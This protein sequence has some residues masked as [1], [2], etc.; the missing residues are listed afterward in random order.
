MM[1]PLLIAVTIAHALTVLTLRRSILSSAAW[2]GDRSEWSVCSDLA[3]RTR[4]LD[5]EHRRERVFS[6]G[7]G[8][9]SSVWLPAETKTAST[10]GESRPFAGRLLVAGD[11]RT[12]A[13]GFDDDVRA[14]VTVRSCTFCLRSEV[15]RTFLRTDLNKSNWRAVG[16]STRDLV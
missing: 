3:G 5:A 13:L 15:E 8:S 1:L 9:R 2:S 4:T 10:G 16:S 14:T 11:L 7:L 12:Y 6:L